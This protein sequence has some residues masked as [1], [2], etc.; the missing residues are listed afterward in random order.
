MCL[1]ATGPAHRARA[2]GDGARARQQKV[3]EA[4]LLIK[5]RRTKES[6]RR[7]HSTGC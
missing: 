3:A 4:V 1:R 2:G 6:G 7:R 5:V